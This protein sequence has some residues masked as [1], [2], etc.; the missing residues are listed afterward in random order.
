MDDTLDSSVLTTD[1]D[2]NN[3]VYD[4]TDYSGFGAG[5]VS[6]P[7]MEHTAFGDY[8]VYPDAYPADLV[9]ASNA[10]HESEFH[11]LQT[12]WDHIHH[13]TGLDIQGTDADKASFDSMLTYGL[14]HSAEFRATLE[15]I[16]TD[17]AHTERIN[18][19]HN[20]VGTIGDSFYTNAVDLTDLSQFPA[21]PR[22]G[23]HNE[24]TRTEELDHILEERHS[25][26]EARH[27]QTYTFDPN[28][29][30]DRQIF[31]AAHQEGID[32]QNHVRDELGQSHVV[33][34]KPT[35][36]ADGSITGGDFHYANGDDE[37]L[38]IDNLID[39]N[40]T[41]ITPPNDH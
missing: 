39:A 34:Q 20:Q 38:H 17:P 10:I 37:V 26:L 22:A 28:N 15:D 33:S 7:H 12:T 13:G 1:Q 40:I 11:T 19:G 32:S 35:R 3:Q 2:P 41:S 23:H 31:D 6:G 8:D 30:A 21:A 18:L 36:N 14:Q 25:A 16:G 5:L 9:P 29:P 24:A 4:G 27:A